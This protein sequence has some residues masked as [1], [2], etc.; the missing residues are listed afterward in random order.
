MQRLKQLLTRSS[1]VQQ[2]IV[3]DGTHNDTWVRGGAAYYEAI[4]KF[5]NTLSTD[6]SKQSLEPKHIPVDRSTQRGGTCTDE[7]DIPTM[8]ANMPGLLK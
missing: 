7:N 5:L 4:L 8:S 1:L 3:A 2:H 6:T